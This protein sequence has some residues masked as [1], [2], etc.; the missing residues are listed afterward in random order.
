MR[1]Y[2]F[3]LET[4]T[5]FDVFL[6]NLGSRPILNQRYMALLYAWSNPNYQMLSYELCGKLDSLIKDDPW[7]TTTQSRMFLIALDAWPKGPAES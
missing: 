7:T 6:L 4:R 2:N 1:H 5:C 3:A